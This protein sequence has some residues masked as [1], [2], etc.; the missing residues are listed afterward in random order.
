MRKLMRTMTSA[1]A[2]ATTAYFFDPISGRGR[3]TRL[4]DQLMSKAR[5]SGR[6]IQ[7]K[8]RYQAGRL[9]GVVYEATG[10]ANGHPQQAQAMIQKIRSEAL[11][12]SGLKSSDVDIE[13]DIGNGEVH[14][15]RHTEDSVAWDDFAR[16]VQDVAGVE[17]VHT[18]TTRPVGAESILGG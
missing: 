7:K 12:P 17:A 16:R 10:K 6:E 18:L 5:R 13:V 8:A 1:A 14:L 2:G 11:G 4:R 9:K 3:R 15:T